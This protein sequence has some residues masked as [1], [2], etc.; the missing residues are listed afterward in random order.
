M[1]GAIGA[2]ALRKRTE[3]LRSWGPCIAPSSSLD[4]GDVGEDC[5]RS[6][7][8]LALGRPSST[9]AEVKQAAQ[10]TRTARDTGVAFSLV[11]SSWPNKRQRS[12]GVD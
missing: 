3:A 11:T 4:L 2:V 6:A 9:A 7:E 5:L 12:C 8:T 10:G 1:L